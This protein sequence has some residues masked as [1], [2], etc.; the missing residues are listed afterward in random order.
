MSEAVN[1]PK[2]YNSGK[3][4]VIEFIEDQGFGE[5]FSVGNALKYV[6]RAGKKDPTKTIEDLE[7]AVWYINRRI[8][9]LKAEREGREVRRPNDMNPRTTGEAE[10]EV[11]E[12]QRLQQAMREGAHG[13][14][15]THV[16][17]STPKAPEPPTDTVSAVNESGDV[18]LHGQFFM[19]TPEGQQERLAFV[20]D[21]TPTEPSA[22]WLAEHKA[23]ALIFLD[24]AGERPSDYCTGEHA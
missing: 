8:E 23:T 5:G 6:A 15:A 10:R 17:T 21:M 11:R 9:V 22:E 12:I 3:I 14:S 4:E 18:A 7:K 20:V 1:H 16:L 24:Q 19:I 2:H 13:F